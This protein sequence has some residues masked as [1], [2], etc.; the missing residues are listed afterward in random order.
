VRT[1]PQCTNGPLK[2]AA[3]GDFSAVRQKRMPQNSGFGC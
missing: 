1:N 2:S 3:Q